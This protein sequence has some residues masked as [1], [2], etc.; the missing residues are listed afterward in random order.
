MTPLPMPERTP[1]VTTT[2]LRSEASVEATR[3]ES[4]GGR[5][6]RFVLAWNESER[7]ADVRWRGDRKGWAGAT[8]RE[9]TKT[10]RRRHDR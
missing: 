7:E 5:P 9:R 2:I 3:S 8:S 1:P 10:S 4:L 6:F